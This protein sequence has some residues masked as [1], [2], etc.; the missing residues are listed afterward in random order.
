MNKIEK[1]DAEWKK[2]LTPEQYQVLRKKGTEHPFTGEYVG[3]KMKGVYRCA[4][5]GIE[6]FS[7]ATKFESG[8]GWPSFWQPIAPDHIAYEEDNSHFMHR[9]E[10]LCPVCGGHLGHVFEDGPRPTFKRY[11]IN[12]I[13][14]KF[15]PDPSTRPAS[16][17][18]CSG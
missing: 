8:C 3:H 5:C 10:V 12:S 18:T 2:E 6:L 1:T 15:D 11:C 17:G 13:S 14:L 16:G 4:A 9:I 7:S